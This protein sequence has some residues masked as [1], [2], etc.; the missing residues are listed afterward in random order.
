MLT[1]TST[2]EIPGV[3]PQEVLEFV[4]D[5]ER[6][7]DADHKIVKV[8]TVTG[9][10]ES[11]CGSIKLSG[12]LRYGPAAPDVQN[13][14]LEKWNRLTFTGAPNQPGRLIFNFTGT[15][16]CEPIDAGTKV[17][18]AYEFRFRLP[19][20]LLEPLH[21]SWLQAELD[22]EMERVVRTLAR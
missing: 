12:K 9:P 16:D 10:D 4:L 21:S 18:H 14:V 13:F 6:Y 3:A 5:L 8:G 17:T 22:A 2:V 11:G 7:K 19:F 20:R 1:A 15:F